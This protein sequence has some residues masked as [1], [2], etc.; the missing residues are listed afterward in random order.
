MTQNESNND[1][2]FGKTKEAER[3]DGLKMLER[4]TANAQAI[5]AFEQRKAENQP[6][7]LTDRERLLLLNFR[8]NDERGQKLAERI[9]ALHAAEYPR[10]G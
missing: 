3:A 1:W 7:V 6:L 5:R 2:P 4:M 10:A 8:K 9:V